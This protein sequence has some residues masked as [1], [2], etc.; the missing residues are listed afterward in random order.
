MLGKKLSISGFLLS[1]KFLETLEIAPSTEEGVEIVESTDNPPAR[2]LDTTETA[3]LGG[4]VVVSNEQQRIAQEERGRNRES[5]SS[6][7]RNRETSSSR[8]P[9][10]RTSRTNG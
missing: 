3:P 10:R 6:N 2:A 1:L 5:T 9:G 7:T 4:M 8:S